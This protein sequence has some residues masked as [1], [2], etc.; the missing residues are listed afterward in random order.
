MT[1]GS[2][3]AVRR[4]RA[5]G[6]PRTMQID[7]YKLFVEEVEETSSATALEKL[8]TDIKDAQTDVQEAAANATNSH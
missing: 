2:E 6:L 7:L 3:E 4:L 8:E 1:E 5:S